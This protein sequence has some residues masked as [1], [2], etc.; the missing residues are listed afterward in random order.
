MF[1]KAYVEVIK[2]DT[3]DVITTSPPTCSDELPMD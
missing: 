1:E 2:F 3:I